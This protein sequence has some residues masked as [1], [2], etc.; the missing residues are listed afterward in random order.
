MWLKTYLCR[1]KS[2]Q[3]VIKMKFKPFIVA[4][5]LLIAAQTFAQNSEKLD[6]LPLPVHK[7]KV[8][9]WLNM[10]MGLN[11][12]DCYDNGT[13]PFNYLG[14]GAN[15]N[16]G[17]TIEW[18]RCHVQAEARLFGNMFTSFDGYSFDIDSR[19][20][21]LYR[22]HDSKRNR[23]HLW[24]G[25]GIQ[26]YFD[27]KEIPALMNAAMGVSVFENLCAEGMLQYDFAFIRDGLH[28]LL[29]AY[30]KLSLPIAGLVIRPGYAY[31]DNYTGD[32]NQANTIFQDYQTFGKLF[33]GLGTDIGL[34]LNLL[35]GNRIGFNYRWDYLTT[36][37]KGAYRFDNA[38][39]SF[40]LNLMFNIH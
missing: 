11:V 8:P 32:I 23:L 16:L 20:E 38:L 10:G 27:M 14:V 19:S 15:L 21:F 24:A 5:I 17:A 22:F 12:A 29:T 7:S 37:H 40:N 30:G 2:T 13:I 28:N 33:P 31:L 34:Y 3:H 36:R 25:G 6:T 35:N 9:I 18:R 4:A 26:S 1:T 39:H